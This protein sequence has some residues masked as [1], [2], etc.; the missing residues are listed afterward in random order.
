MKD[1]VTLRHGWLSQACEIVTPCNSSR[2]HESISVLGNVLCVGMALGW[3]GGHEPRSFLAGLD[4][5]PR[6]QLLYW[7]S[8]AGCHGGDSGQ[9]GHMAGLCLSVISSLWKPAFN[10]KAHVHLRASRN[11]CGTPP[12]IH[13]RHHTSPPSWTLAWQFADC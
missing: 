1:G 3:P 10:S 12:K 9:L 2:P 8:R 11:P 5:P 7:V 6:T 13:C 4:C